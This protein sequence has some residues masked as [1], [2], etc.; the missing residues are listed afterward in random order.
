MSIKILYLLS[1]HEPSLFVT[2][3]LEENLQQ[4]MGF[5]LYRAAEMLSF[6]AFF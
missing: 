2:S 1:E 5:L 3:A 4:Q 6:S